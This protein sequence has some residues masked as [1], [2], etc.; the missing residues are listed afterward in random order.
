[1]GKK[2]FC[3]LL[4]LIMP[5]MV[6]CGCSDTISNDIGTEY[7]VGNV[8]LVKVEDSKSFAIFVHKETRVMYLANTETY[9]FGLSVMLNTDGTPMLWEGEL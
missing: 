2:I 9:R 8:Y 3:L 1:M 7:K 6:L 4:L 5:V